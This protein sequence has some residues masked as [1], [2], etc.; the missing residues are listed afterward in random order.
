MSLTHS[1]EWQTVIDSP[2]DFIFTALDG[3]TGLL[4]RD[5][6]KF[7]FRSFAIA[8]LTLS[9]IYLDL[10]ILEWPPLDLDQGLMDYI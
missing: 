4:G 6:L 7:L 5:H 8:R 1:C 9:N 2:F 10:V 3:W